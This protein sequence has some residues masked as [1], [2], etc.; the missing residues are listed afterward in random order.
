[1]YKPLFIAEEGLYF[2]MKISYIY[3]LRINLKSIFMALT[4]AIVLYILI[5]LALS[6]VI[7][8]A[9]WKIY[10]KAGKPGWAVLIPIYNTL[11][12]L[13]IVGKPWWWILLMLIPVVNMVFVIWMINLLSKSFG[14]DE[15]YTIGLILLPIVFYPLLGFGNA[16]Y[17][18]PAGQAT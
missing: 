14:K 17:Q 16:E 10:T 1:M 2:W 6:I 8:V 7:I 3:L 13:E 18:G 5:V 12:M 15:G 11:V 4:F 9:E